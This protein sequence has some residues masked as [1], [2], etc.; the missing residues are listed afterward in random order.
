MRTLIIV[1][2]VAIFSI[3][4]TSAQTTASIYAAPSYSHIADLDMPI[5]DALGY[6]IGVNLR[7]GINSVI[8]ID[9]S[10]YFANQRTT[11]SDI[12]ICV[13]SV[14]TLLALNLL[15]NSGAYLICGAEL[16]HTAGYKIEGQRSFLDD[17]I[18]AAAVVGMGYQIADPIAFVARYHHT[19]N[20]NGSGYD[21]SIQVG[22]NVT[23]Y[24]D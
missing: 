9:G 1:S 22:F 20:N 21:Y 13:R 6:A 23:L 15:T 4:R 14:N 16:G 8:G 18:R 5:G 24:K 12:T 10:M 3:T 17:D 2:L 19:L 7:Y 11:I